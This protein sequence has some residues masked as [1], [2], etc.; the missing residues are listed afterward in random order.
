MDMELGI[1]ASHTDA[2]FALAKRHGLS[3]IE[4]DW[5]VGNDCQALYDEREHIRAL[6]QKHGVRVGNIGR[7]GSDKIDA[8]GHVIEEELQNSYRLIDLCAA[9]GVAAFNTGVNHVDAL[10]KY[11]NVTAAIQFL[12]KLV[13]HGRQMGVKICTY[14]C[15]WN[16]FIR[17]PEIWSLVH[18]HIPELGIK[19]DP[20]HC[21]NH[22]SGRYLEEVRDWGGRF[23]HVHIKGTLNVGGV[24]VDDPPAGMDMINWGAFMGLLYAAR[25]DGTLSVEPHSD[26]WRGALAD[27]GIACTVRHISPRPTLTSIPAAS[28]LLPSRKLH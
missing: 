9:L 18:G 22:G 12:Q 4:I 26:V 2:G 15:D 11:E 27:L 8:R 14:N 25:Y 10:S 23:Y 19:Y 13:D 3:F 28:P 21:V 7:W 24:H 20:T 16:N 6:A 5:N 1:I 17:T